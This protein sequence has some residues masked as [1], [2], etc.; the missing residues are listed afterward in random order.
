[1]RHILGLWAILAL[2][3]G[4]VTAQDSTADIA[5]PPSI[6]GSNL[7]QDPGSA[8]STSDGV[9]NTEPIPDGVVPRPPSGDESNP[10]SPGPAKQGAGGLGF[11][12]FGGGGGMG[13][14]G[15]IGG[16]GGAAYGSP[17][18]GGMMPTSS[19]RVTWMPT[20]QVSGQAAHLGFVEQDLSLSCPIYGDD[21]NFL[22]VHAGVRSQTFQTDAFL[23]NTTEPFPDQFWSV[24]LGLM[25]FH[26][27]DNGWTGG[28]MITGGSASN[29]PFADVNQLN[30]SVAAFLRIPSGEHNAWNFS[31]FYSPL[32]Q[33]PIPIPGV[34]FYWQPS[35]HFAANIGLPFQ[36][37]YLPTDDIGLDF[38]Y[39]L[40]TTVHARATFNIRRPIRFYVGYDWLNQG[41]RLDTDTNSTNR[42]FYYE[43]RVAT[44]VQYRYSRHVFV[45]LSTGY[46]FDRFYSEGSIFGQSSQD[47]LGIA[48]SPYLAGS[49]QIR[50]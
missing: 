19:Y 48:P 20:Q 2:S 26:R 12:G 1:M 45:E 39:M 32:G 6:P 41:Y 11:G 37:R 5:P 40:L 13:G 8:P 29:R 35:D 33:I 42:F 31:L 17:G 27:F 36:I 21:K 16:F 49:A 44:G 9:T 25:G 23:P 4:S 34:S 47:R 22:A 18:A 10:A 24:N 46:A 50:W 28:G 3:V 38:S 43:Q 14:F 30:A 15:G 7:P